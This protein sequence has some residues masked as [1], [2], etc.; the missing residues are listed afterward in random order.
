MIGVEGG[1]GALEQIP[2]RWPHSSF[3]I[4]A[5]AGMTIW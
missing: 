1:S 4:P 3:V 2:L 5:F